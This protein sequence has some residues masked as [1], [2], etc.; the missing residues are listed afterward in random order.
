MPDSQMT[1]DDIADIIQE[2]AQQ[3]KDY[4]LSSLDIEHG[5]TRIRLRANSTSVAKIDHLPPVEAVTSPVA[6]VEN[7]GQLLT[8]PMIGTFYDAPASGELPFVQVGD[9]IEVGQVVGIIEAMKIMN[10]IPSDRAGLVDEILVRNSQPVEYG[11]PLLRIVP[12][13]E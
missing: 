1:W 7:A 11:Q 9:R 12:I 4:G 13:G 6:P 8:A 3:M 10:E 2:A 5:G